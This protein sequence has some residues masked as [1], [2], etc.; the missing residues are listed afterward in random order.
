MFS[1]ILCLFALVFLDLLSEES[2]LCGSSSLSHCSADT[3]S[4]FGL[5]L[6]SGSPDKIRELIRINPAASEQCT[7]VYHL[8][9]WLLRG[10]TWS[11]PPPQRV[12]QSCLFCQTTASCRDHC[13]LEPYDND[14]FCPRT[15]MLISS[16]VGYFCPHHKCEYIYRE[17]ASA[18]RRGNYSTR[19]R[20]A[21]RDRCVLEAR[22]K[23]PPRF[24]SA[25]ARVL[26]FGSS[27]KFIKVLVN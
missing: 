18:R 9:R 3:L 16:S 27:A 22:G 20:E 19:F 10:R 6:S 25:A 24:I 17:L 8:A 5:L 23:T 2:A 11:V 7:S 12:A 14:K 1:V 21:A 26:G 15:A 13:C 4:D